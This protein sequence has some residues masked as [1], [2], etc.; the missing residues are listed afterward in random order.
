MTA[1]ARLEHAL[2]GL[3]STHAPHPRVQSGTARLEQLAG[4]LDDAV[5]LPGTSNRFGIDSVIGL[6]PGIG[7]GLSAVL[8]AYIVV[9]AA[10]L[11]VP[12]AVL[13]RMLGNV[14]IDTAVGTIPIVGSIFD[15]FFHASRRNVKLALEALAI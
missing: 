11:G 8:Q 9:E 1:V 13:G 3:F 6:L 4:W 2:P 5:P 12:H 10:R 15:F 7:D 14:A